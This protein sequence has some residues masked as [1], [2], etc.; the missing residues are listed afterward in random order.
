MIRIHNFAGGA[1]G[2]RLMWQCEEMG[3]PYEVALVSFPPSVAY[4]ALNPLGTVPF[5]EDAGGVAITESIAMMLYLAQRYGPT[6]LLP[7]AGDVRF[8]RV[9][10]LT[11]LAEATM[12]AGMNP[13]LA[14]HFAAPEA[15]KRNWSVRGLEA[16]VA[17]TIDF[18]AALLGEG[19]Y[20][21]GD[22]ITLA[23]IALVTSLS[24]WRG[25]L[26]RELPP[27]LVAYQERLA[28]RPAYRRAR[29]ACG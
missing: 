21:A 20:I 6:P 3:L 2:L 18:V 17:K 8:A 27:P 28:S 15:D 11:V 7:A 23:D 22:D 4:R 10:E 25:G 14:A 19:A 5:L 12:G 9:L 29:A 1:R 13:L 24:I 26:R 16:R